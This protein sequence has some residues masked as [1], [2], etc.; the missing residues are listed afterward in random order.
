MHR[1]GTSA[2]ARVLGLHGAALPADPLPANDW[3]TSG[4]WEP[5]GVVTLHDALLSEAGSRWDDPTS[6]P[7]AWIDSPPGQRYVEALAAAVRASYGDAPLF[8]LKD[9][10]MCRLMPVW[11]Q[12][13]PRL[14]C[15]PLALMVVRHPLEVAASLQRR[16]GLTQAHALLLWLQHVVAAEAATR[17]MPRVV[18]TYHDLLAD[19]KRALGRIETRL[20]VRFPPGDADRDANVSRFLDPSLR[21]AVLTVSDLAHPEIPTWIHDVYAWCLDAAADRDPDAGV[22]DRVRSELQRAELAFSPL[23]EAHRAREQ[24]MGRWLERAEQAAA[25][26]TARLE[27]AGARA[28]DAAE[29]TRV[30]VE[31][32]EAAIDEDRR[33]R[34]DLEARLARIERTPYWRIYSWMIRWRDRLIGPR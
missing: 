13:L 11:R 18:L 33:V 34:A 25:A 31:G 27:D 15:E 19:W 26:L 8:V 30:R 1:S 20:G 28:R 2:L 14:G 10:R 22:L 29:A 9:P 17:A 5:A 16:D 21:H 12:V 23:L 4:Y 7:S 24:D 6:F 32:L 3:N